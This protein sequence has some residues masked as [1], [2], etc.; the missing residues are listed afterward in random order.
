MDEVPRNRIG[1]V[2]EMAAIAAIINTNTSPLDPALL[3][4]VMSATTGRRVEPRVR[5]DGHVGLATLSQDPDSEVSASADG[6]VWAVLDGR[7]DERE[8]LV[9]AL[10]RADWQPDP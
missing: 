5:V 2:S 3:G 10:A 7:L 1:C 8:A 6:T 9:A 4:A